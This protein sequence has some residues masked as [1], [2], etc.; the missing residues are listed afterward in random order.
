MS[1]LVGLILGT[2]QSVIIPLGHN[3]VIGYSYTWSGKAGTE[4]SN[5]SKM[6]TQSYLQTKKEVIRFSP[7]MTGLTLD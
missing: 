2:L 1:C 7:S 5:F 6:D 4:L 3:G